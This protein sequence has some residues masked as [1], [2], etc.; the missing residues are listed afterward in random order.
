MRWVCLAMTFFTV[1]PVVLGI[2][3]FP[4]GEEV[5]HHGIKIDVNGSRTDFCLSCHEHTNCKT[6]TDCVP[7]CS[8][9]VSHLKNQ[10]YPPSNRRDKYNPVSFVEKRGIIFVNGKIDC[11]S[12][13]NLQGN[14]PYHLRII[15]E[16]ELCHVCHDK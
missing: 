16:N 12:C 3:E 6:I 13:H 2:S 7:V 10:D 8:Y 5:T 4:R 14:N 11:I 15:V 1:I 9:G